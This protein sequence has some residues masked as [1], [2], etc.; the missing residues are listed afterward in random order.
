[1]RKAAVT[2]FICLFVIGVYSTS[3]ADDVSIR[4]NLEN[5]ETQPRDGGGFNINVVHGLTFGNLHP[6]HPSREISPNSAEAAKIHLD[7]G[8]V[9]GDLDYI[10]WVG[11]LWSGNPTYMLQNSSGR[12]ELEVTD[13]TTNLDRL[14]GWVFDGW[15]GT[16]KN[17]IDEFGIGATLQDIPY[18]IEAGRY[19]AQVRVNLFLL[20]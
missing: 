14:S 7:A 18:N 8:N 4:E 5:I 11:S 19:N 15:L 13:F 1:M 3:F 9:E 6:G 12:G 16:M 2:I 17:G 10:L 20:D